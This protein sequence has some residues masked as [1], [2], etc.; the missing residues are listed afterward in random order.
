MAQGL[1]QRS[2]WYSLPARVKVVVASV[3][4]PAASLA[5]REEF[6]RKHGRLYCERCGLDRV[7]LFGGIEGEACIEVHHDKVHVKN[8]TDSHTTTL[9]DLRCLCANCH[10]FVHRMLRSQS[11]LL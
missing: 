10:R 5:K 6:R 3:K 11:G 1:V 7:S 4:Q 2:G 9:D 8:M